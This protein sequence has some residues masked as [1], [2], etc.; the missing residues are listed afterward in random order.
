MLTLGK[1][2]YMNFHYSILQLKNKFI[3]LRIF[4]SKNNKL[5]KNA[6]KL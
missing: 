2:F 4:V 1:N 3:T 5:W 6:M